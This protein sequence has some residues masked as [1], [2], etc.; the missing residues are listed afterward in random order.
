[1]SKVIHI[2]LKPGAPDLSETRFG[3]VPVT[4]T[5]T[6]EEWFAFLCRTVGR[7]LSPLGASTYNQ[8]AASLSEQLQAAS[9]AH[10]LKGGAR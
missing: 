5:L 7:E 8:A 9:R 3:K 1:M 4:I 10:L 2:K 6:G